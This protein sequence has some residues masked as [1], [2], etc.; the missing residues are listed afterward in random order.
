MYSYQQS[1][2]D[3]TFNNQN[4]PADFLQYF[5]PQYGDLED[6]NTR[7]WAIISWAD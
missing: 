1:I 6:G 3:N 2:G 5:D 7:R 4:L